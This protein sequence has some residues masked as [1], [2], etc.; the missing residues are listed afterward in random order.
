VAPAPAPVRARRATAPARRAPAAR[1]ARTPAPPAGRPRRHLAVVDDTRAKVARR[2]RRARALVLLGG[3]FVV[4]S[5]FALAAS[6]AYLATGQSRLD[7]L[8]RDVAD[9]QAR[10]QSLRLDVAELEAPERIVREAQERLGMVP[11]PDVTY[12][13]PSAATADEMDAA[14]APSPTSTEAGERAAYATMKPYLT[15]RP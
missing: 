1:P 13:S 4:G 2:R 10:Y 7:E 12:I 6:H 11:P 9:A 15:G 14:S 3:V 5:L 8:E